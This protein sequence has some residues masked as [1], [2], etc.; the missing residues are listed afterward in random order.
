[1]SPGG[2]FKKWFYDEGHGHPGFQS[3]GIEVIISMGKTTVI[4][5]A[6]YKMNV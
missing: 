6:V 3:P 2:V 5:H 1:V 4:S